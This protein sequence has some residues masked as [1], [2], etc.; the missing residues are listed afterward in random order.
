VERGIFE[1]TCSSCGSVLT[2]AHDEPAELR[3]AS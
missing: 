2:E 1:I 3:L